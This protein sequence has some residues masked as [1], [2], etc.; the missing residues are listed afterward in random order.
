M[1]PA[2]PDASA[3]PRP[4]A[5]FAEFTLAE[6]VLLASREDGLRL[7]L[8]PQLLSGAALVELI[9]AGRL[10]SVA[11]GRDA[12][13]RVWVGVPGDPTP[14]GLPP[15]DVALTALARRGS[16][17]EVGSAARDL[18]GPVAAATVGL[19]AA[20]GLVHPLGEGRAPLAVT[21]ADDDRVGAVQEAIA[22]LRAMPERARSPRSG[23]LLA[24]IAAGPWRMDDIV[25][26]EQSAALERWFSGDLLRA[27][28]GT[29]AAARA[30]SY[31][32]G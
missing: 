5:S 23:A 27:L 13:P 30:T 15:L 31:A 28:R 14:L 4:F 3:G 29:L 26:K 18:G 12:F 1:I 25:F 10:P 6:A 24:L 8:T 16:S 22:L 9:L 20:R 2:R 11:E 21:I 7:S 17:W 19:L 32:V